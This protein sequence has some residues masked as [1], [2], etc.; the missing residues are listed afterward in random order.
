MPLVID[1]EDLSASYEST[2]AA[3]L[4]YIGLAQDAPASLPPPRLRRQSDA[5]SDDWV[6]RYRRESSGHG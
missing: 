4:R 3:V 2:I 5:I 6:Y 1:Y